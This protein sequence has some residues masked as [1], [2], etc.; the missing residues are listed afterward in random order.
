MN[1]PFLK[2]WIYCHFGLITQQSLQNSAVR[3]SAVMLLLEGK[4]KNQSNEEKFKFFDTVFYSE[5]FF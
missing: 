5:D 3:H 2:P 1:D 4:M